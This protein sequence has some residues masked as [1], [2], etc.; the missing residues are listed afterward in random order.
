MPSPLSV[1]HAVPEWLLWL[2]AASVAALIVS[3]LMLIAAVRGMRDE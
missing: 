1:L 2:G 3:V